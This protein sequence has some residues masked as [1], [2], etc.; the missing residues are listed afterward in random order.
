MTKILQLKLEKVKETWRKF[1]TH[2]LHEILLLTKYYSGDQITKNL[3][4]GT[5]DTS[6][7]GNGIGYMGLVRKSGGKNLL[8]KPSCGWENNNI[9]YAK[10]TGWEGVYLI[11]LQ[12]D[13]EDS[14][15][16]V[17]TVMDLRDLYPLDT[18]RP[19]YRRGV[20]LL[21]ENAFYIFNKEIYFII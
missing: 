21:S 5:C 1:Y 14:G 3:K 7:R 13:R 16:V 9:M 18:V 6:V 4:A 17:N 20:S 12:Q 15:A 8:G 11:D 2:E 19:V 10:A